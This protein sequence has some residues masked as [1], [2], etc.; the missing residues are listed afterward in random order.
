MEMQLRRTRLSPTAALGALYRA[1]L[2]ASGAVA[3]TTWEAQRA[4]ILG[5]TVDEA[6]GL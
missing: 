4:W 5:R 6:M 1:N 2:K 3:D